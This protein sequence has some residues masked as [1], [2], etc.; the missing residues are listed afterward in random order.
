MK[1]SS[2]TEIKGK[3]NGFIILAKE[4]IREEIVRSSV[5][6]DAGLIEIKLNKTTLEEVFVKLVG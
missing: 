6:L 2:I 5:E 4:D 1:L 3:D